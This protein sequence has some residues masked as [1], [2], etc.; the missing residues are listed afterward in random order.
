MSL[1]A[2]RRRYERIVQ[3][4]AFLPGEILALLEDA[5][6]VPILDETT[7]Q[8]LLP[9]LDQLG[10]GLER[11]DAADLAQAAFH[12]AADITLSAMRER[13][14]PP[15]YAIVLSH[16]LLEL[17]RTEAALQLLGEARSV[18]QS[19]GGNER[20]L[21]LAMVDNTLADQLRL[22]GD[23]DQAE[24][25]VGLALQEYEAAP[26][27]PPLLHSAILN[28]LG[29]VLQEKGALAEASGR[30]RDSLQILAD[31]QGDPADLAIGLDNLAAIE[32]DL[33]SK[34]GPLEI[35]PGYVNL[36]VD[37][38]LR[39]AD[40]YLSRARELFRGLGPSREADYAISF[41]HAVTLA[42]LRDDKEK[43]EQYSR[44]ALAILERVGDPLTIWSALR[45]RAAVLGDLGDWGAVITLL[46]PLMDKAP[47]DPNAAAAFVHLA[48]A[49]ARTGDRALSVE[50]AGLVAAIDDQV[51][52]RR[53]LSASEQEALDLFGPFNAR[54]EAVLGAGLAVAAH[55]ICPDWL[56]EFTLN[57]KGLLSERLGSAWTQA[58]SADPAVQ[59]LVE[60]VRTLRTQAARLDLE[61]VD[62]EPIREARG[63]RAEASRLAGVAEAN[64]L[65]AL[66][67][68]AQAPLR[69]TLKDVRAALTAESLLLDLAV[70]CTAH[71]ERRYVVFAVR[72][73]GPVTLRDLGS[74]ADLDARIEALSRALRQPS[75]ESPWIWIDAAQDLGD[76]IFP[77]DLRLSPVLRIAPVGLWSWVPFCLLPADGRPLIDDHQVSCI[78]SGRWLG[79]RT[80]QA[81]AEL[82]PR[83]PPLVMGDPD[84]DLGRP[85]KRAFLLRRRLG[86]LPQAALEAQAVATRLG[87]EALIGASATR[88]ALVTA[89]GPEVL[90]LATHGMMLDAIG[91]LAEQAEPRAYV[92]RA[93]DG[94]VVS[95]KLDG[96]DRTWSP[97]MAPDPAGDPARAR[98]LSRVRW[99]WEIGPADP[100]SRSL[101]ALAGANAWLEGAQTPSEIGNG[102][103]TAGE[104]A[105]LD[106][107]GTRLVV[108]SA[109][110]T[111][112]GPVSVGDGAL[113]GLRTAGLLAGAASN[114]STLWR[115]HD[116]TST[117]LISH[118][119]DALAR[120]AARDEAVREAQLKIRSKTSDPH[121]WAAWVLDGDAG[122]L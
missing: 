101:V 18:I 8:A 9:L 37:E 35:A 62:G 23:L 113:V 111:G 2:I 80:V 87:V 97:T 32:L 17:G 33:A 58:Y 12:V 60:D 90:H 112:V 65:R 56:Y 85:A 72:D 43:A 75:P 39:S 59:R 5:R 99:L 98:H 110:E 94:I 91:S 71:D 44:E 104:F 15:R 84:F 26:D 118:V 53:L 64:L 4:D 76:R 102:L 68:E 119:Y 67:R 30:L 117:K 7:L 66:G 88:Q 89:R 73:E 49:A 11:A 45:T 54:A 116:A 14:F 6:A 16:K 51:L 10:G 41:G 34:A 74:V 61:G 115:V 27:G 78:P 114:L 108:L 48:C 63:R 19:R 28:N 46:S 86:R 47:A 25:A 122:P 40:E 100:R 21:R 13:G 107:A 42:R 38:H 95:E 96:P 3:S 55:G 121:Y 109:C 120:G 1:D 92:Q 83:S 22:A 82:A 52:G 81:G 36:I 20:G 105:L 31:H 24:Q 103:L 29:L 57:R 70:A 93:V 79:A 106:L 77:H 50:V 69:I